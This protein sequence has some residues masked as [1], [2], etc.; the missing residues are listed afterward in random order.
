MKRE[1]LEEF[2]FNPST[3]QVRMGQSIA[4]TELSE[5]GGKT[6]EGP[7]AG[8]GGGG[9]RL[10]ASFSPGFGGFGSFG[11]FGRRMIRDGGRGGS[12]EPDG[13]IGG[14]EWRGP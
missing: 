4:S 7:R 9:A 6:E 1:R 5:D 11:S 12:R 10:R 14:E 8:G 3:F 2:L 13:V